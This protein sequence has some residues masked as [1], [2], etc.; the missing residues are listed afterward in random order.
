[1]YIYT[2][3]NNIVSIFIKD[4]LLESQEEIFISS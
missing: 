3:E 1:M 2:Y 4:E